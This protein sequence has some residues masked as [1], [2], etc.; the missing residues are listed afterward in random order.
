L[1][2]HFIIGKEGREGGG[3][4]GNIENR[5]M[6]GNVNMQFMHYVLPFTVSIAILALSVI[7]SIIFMLSQSACKTM[8]YIEN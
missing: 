5:G 2:L 6:G 8:V 1:K 3:Q 7:S 4:K